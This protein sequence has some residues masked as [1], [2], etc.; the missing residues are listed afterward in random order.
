[1][2]FED[3]LLIT[4]KLLIFFLSKTDWTEN[5]DLLILT[6]VHI[7]KRKKFQCIK[8]VS[9]FSSFNYWSYYFIFLVDSYFHWSEF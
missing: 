1:V 8:K 3:L 5:C 7:L 2:L 9:T 6:V 4:F